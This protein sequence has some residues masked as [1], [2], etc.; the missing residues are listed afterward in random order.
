MQC[1]FWY[2]KR[3]CYKPLSDLANDLFVLPLLS[4]IMYSISEK[5][6]SCHLDQSRC[7]QQIAFVKYEVAEKAAFTSPTGS[8]CQ[9]ALQEHSDSLTH[10]A[11]SIQITCCCC[12]LVEG[13]FQLFFW[14]SIQVM[15]YVSN[16]VVLTQQN[17]LKLCRFGDILF[18]GQGGK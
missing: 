8:I 2:S 11:G 13:V 14:L 9:S 1:V 16:S 6:I 12:L 4:Q 18:G 17:G 10:V 5:D 7:T 15:Q 3:K